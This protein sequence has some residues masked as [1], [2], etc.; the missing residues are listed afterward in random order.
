LTAVR[1]VWL[2]L[3]SARV[4]RWV[5]PSALRGH[6]SLV[7][8]RVTAPDLAV[9]G[10]A[11]PGSTSAPPTGPRLSCGLRLT[12]PASCTWLLGSPIVG[13]ASSVHSAFASPCAG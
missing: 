10:N 7:L 2:P 11:T 1:H 12:T 5:H 13:L 3:L 4:R 6:E 9:P 8:S